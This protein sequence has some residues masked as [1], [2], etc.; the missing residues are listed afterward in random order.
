[1]PVIV[2]LLEERWTPTTIQTAFAFH[3]LPSTP[4]GTSINLPLS[5]LGWTFTLSLTPVKT[6]ASW[7]HNRDRQPGVRRVRHWIPAVFSF[8]RHDIA[9][10]WGNTSINARLSL[11]EE[12]SSSLLGA[13]DVVLTETLMSSLNLTTP[14]TIPPHERNK[15]WLSVTISKCPLVN[16]LFDARL[17]PIDEA[18]VQ[19]QL[20]RQSGDR[21]L[22]RSLTTGKLFDVKFLTNPTRSPLGNPLPTYASL[23]VLKKHVDLSSCK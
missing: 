17:G 21:V 6:G 9:I 10:G 19:E 7:A 15:I 2:E 23:S 12:Y 20:V 22:S 3:S 1:M 5:N 11:G 18:K 16:G 14:F 13:M 4:S 8:R